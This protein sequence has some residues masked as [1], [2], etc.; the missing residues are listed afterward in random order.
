M[1]TYEFTCSVEPQYL[2][3]QSD[4]VQ[5]VYAFAYTVTIENTGDVAAFAF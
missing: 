3:E 1:S 4:P 2:P 5:G